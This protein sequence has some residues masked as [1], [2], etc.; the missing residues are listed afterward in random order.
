MPTKPSRSCGPGF[1][2]F[3]PGP[4]KITAGAACPPDVPG[5]FVSLDVQ[6]CLQLPAAERQRAAEVARGPMGIRDLL[7]LRP[8]TDHD[9]RG[10]VTHPG[11]RAAS[12]ATPA[13]ERRSVSAEH[14]ALVG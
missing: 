5:A 12:A 14:Q 7:V 10:D 6:V 3:T 4:E 11:H 1:T 2:K 9:L 8:G 13:R